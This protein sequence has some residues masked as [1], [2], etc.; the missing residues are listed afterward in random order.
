MRH[1]MKHYIDAPE[2]LKRITDNMMVPDHQRMLRIP[3]RWERTFVIIDQCSMM[4][5]KMQ[6]YIRESLQASIVLELG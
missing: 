6:D 2:V 1:L 5:N 4:D 3:P